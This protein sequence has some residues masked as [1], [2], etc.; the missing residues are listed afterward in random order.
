MTSVQLGGSQRHG[1]K[2]REHVLRVRRPLPGLR[3]VPRHGG[4]ARHGAHLRR[5]RRPLRRAAG[6][7]ARSTGPGG[8]SIRLPLLDDVSGIR[9]ALYRRRCDRR[10]GRTAALRHADRYHAEPARVRAAA[11]DRRRAPGESCEMCGAGIVDEHPHVVNIDSPQPAVH[12]PACYLLFTREGA[13]RGNYRAVPDRYLVDPDVELTDARWDAAPGA[14]RRWRSSSTTACSAGSSRSTRA[15]PA[16]PS[17]CS[18]WRPGTTIAAA[19]PLAADARARRRGAHRAPH[20]REQRVLPRADRRLLR[21]GRADPHALDRLRRRRGGAAGHRRTSSRGCGRTASDPLDGGAGRCLSS[22]STASTSA[23]I[24]TPP[25]PTLVFRL[26]IAET[27]GERVHAIALRCQLRIEPQK[28]RYTASRGRAAQRPVRRHRRAGPTRSSRCSSPTVAAM[29][30]SFTGGVEVDLPVPCTYD[31]EIAATSY[32]HALQ[33]G[34]IPLL[35]LFSGTIF[36]RGE[37]GFSVAQVPWHKEA[38]LPAA[39]HGMAGDDGPRSSRTAAGCGCAATPWRRWVRSRTPERCR[40]GS[41]RDDAARRSAGSAGDVT[42]SVRAGRHGRPVRRR[43]A[44]RRRRAVRGLRALPLPR[45]VAGRTR[46]AGSSACL[47]PPGY[48][49]DDPSER[50]ACQTEMVFEAGPTPMLGCAL[51]FLHVQHRTRR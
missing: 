4:A 40:P 15:R 22:S 50:S 6:R 16:R 44:G 18:T 47:M 23:P 2:D 24:R 48:V 39:G 28:R 25:G 49:A 8:I 36:T 13:G 31:L 19:N 30:P 26:R 42:R 1:G 32:F 37:T 10:A 7:S 34:E 41:W 45:I 35:L 29:V 33:E 5:V 9:V 17:R 20:R 11:V 46:T 43:A 38:E 3:G 51:R 21:A 12:V 14:G 27:T